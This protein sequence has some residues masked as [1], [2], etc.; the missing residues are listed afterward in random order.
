MSPSPG[1]KTGRCASQR[2][3]RPVRAQTGQPGRDGP[4][5]TLGDRESNAVPDPL[6]ERSGGDLDARRDPALRMAGRPALPL[7]KLLELLQ[8]E[9]IPGQK[10]QARV[11]PRVAAQT[12]SAA[13]RRTYKSRRCPPRPLSFDSASPVP[14]FGKTQPCSA[15]SRAFQRHDD[16]EKAYRCGSSRTP[17]HSTQTTRKSVPSH[18]SASGQ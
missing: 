17:H 4:S 13:F 6:T 3:G 10:Q 14:R 9:V 16:S 15:R 2:A 8:R 7:S 12:R 11:D 1:V 5:D 18:R